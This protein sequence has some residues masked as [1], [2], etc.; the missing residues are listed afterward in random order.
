MIGRE[1]ELGELRTLVTR[2]RVVAVHGAAGIGKTT[3]VLAACREAARENAIPP[4]VHLALAGAADPRDA[5]ER[6][7]KAIGEPR[8]TPPPDRVAEALSV[9]LSSAPRTVVWD[10]LDE[11]S[12]PL[13]DL[14]RRFA[15]HDGQAR[16]V[17]VSRRLITA[18]EAAFRAPAYE[19][20]PLSHV[21]AVRLVRALEEERGR[22]LAD[23]LAEATAGNPLLLKVALAEAAL[24]RVEANATD[25][26]RHSIEERAKGP[27]RK[28]L[29]ILAAADGPLDEAQVVAVIGRGAR[30]AVDE[31]R[32]HL[33]VVRE[34]ARI[35]LAPPVTT[36]AQEMLG[37]PDAATWKTIAT[38][39]EHGLASSG[40]DDAALVLAARAQLALGD[41]D[42]ALHLLREHAIAR[43]A[44]PTA[45][46]E[47]V[48][49]DVASRSPGHAST[50]LRLLA[51]E[52][53]RVGDYETA[54]LTLDE[55]PAAASREEAERV[56]LLRAECHIRAGEPEA[57]QRALEA[58][59]RL[60]ARADAK[61]KSKTPSKGSAAASAGIVLTLA[62]LAILRG[63]LAPARATLVALAPRT[64]DVP[65]LEARR[66]VEIAASHLYEERY[67]LTHAWTSRAR[68]AQKAGGIPV[69]RVVTILDVH[70]L[71]GL[72]E[73]DRAEE[74]LAR[75]TR[76]RPDSG[77]LEIAALVRRGEL[78]RA[79]EVGDA[80]IAALDRRADRLFRS[81]LA[82]DL[83]RACIGT[84]QLARADRMLG[85]AESAG[86]EPGLAALRPICDAERARLAEAEGDAA[87]AAAS[88]ERA[89]ARIPGSPF[90]AIDRDVM[91]GRCPAD[92]ASSPIAGEDREASP[93]L[94]PVARAYAALRGAE[95]ALEQGH[96]EAALDGADLAERY[97]ATARLWYE[98]ARSRLARAESLTRLHAVAA[99]EGERNKLRERAARA[100]DGCEE[101]A[102]AQGYAPILACAGIVRAALE[103]ASGD[104]A[105]AGRAIEVA[106]RSAGEGLDAPLVRAAARLGVAAREPRGAGPRP[107][108]AR[109]ARL[110][111]LRSADV[112]WRVGSRT[113]LRNRADAAPEPVACTVD[114]ED[115]RVRVGDGKEIELPEQRLALLSALAESGDG[116]ASLEE[117]FA[118]VWGGSFH[119]L[120]HRNA[121]YV[122]LARLKESL[123]PFA[124]DIRITH[125]GD[126]YRL[127]GP[128]PV[129]VRRRAPSAT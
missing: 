126:R 76:G 67:E 48:L 112:V 83:A 93:P 33:L 123:R 121:V 99:T 51:R 42:R 13:A 52:L 5:V 36:L 40:H 108:A 43:A 8:P 26:L 32:K 17:I 63:E 85:L 98:T 104:L 47:R 118:R 53:L 86:D 39:A 119:P 59:Q 124:R 77:A 21:D 19:V 109:I 96:L 49:R 62:Q 90:V 97:H 129:A 31:L 115:R 110:G 61:G 66:A 125:D 18:P 68:A 106:V 122:A 56:A 57:A 82:R 100:L 94:P 69:E 128:L 35:A 37:A 89:F 87:R 1:R 29:A 65:Q 9:L 41:V 111:L 16:L 7:A 3:L 30:E 22:T 74:V 120:R 80:A 116:G 15:S 105:A 64:T 46:M 6:T 55:L 101:I 50:A 34:D 113:Y 72:G 23:D 84:G 95:L 60:S 11:R 70:A 38:L 4:V 127:A 75:E 92:Q 79:L 45:A 10:D 2:S 44:A 25:A 14:I 91:A 54:R 107:H 103:E 27:A 102:T 114:L 117:I 78:T 81:V 20:P 24:P 73:V 58:L 71:L 88:I 28:L 12:A